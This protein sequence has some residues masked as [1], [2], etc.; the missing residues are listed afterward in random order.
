MCEALILNKQ[1]I[2]FEAAISITV[3]CCLVFVFIPFK[4][5]A[6]MQLIFKKPVSALWHK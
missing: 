4:F 6:L 1:H 5:L 2:K 3:L